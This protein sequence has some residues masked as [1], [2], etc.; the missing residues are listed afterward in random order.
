MSSATLTMTQ[1]WRRELL[2]E[3][4]GSK[5][6]IRLA[7]KHGLYERAA[8]QRARMRQ[9]EKLFFP[10]SNKG[11]SPTPTPKAKATGTVAHGPRRAEILARAA[12]KT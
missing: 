8:K 7:H 4:W 12:S 2:L 1:E 9:I 6:I 10:D 5:R 11:R 3:W